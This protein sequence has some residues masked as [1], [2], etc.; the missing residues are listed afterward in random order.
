MIA[1]KFPVDDNRGRGLARSQLIGELGE[2]SLKHLEALGKRVE[3][4]AGEVLF[5]QEDAGDSIYIVETGSIEISIL[6]VSGKKLALNVMQAPDVFGEIA[7]LDGGPRTATATTLEP[8]TLLRFDRAEI[9]QEIKNRPELAANLI[10]IL[11]ARLR[12]VSQQVEDLAMLNIEGRLASRLLILHKKFS[13]KYGKLHLS[14]SELAEFLGAT[15]ESINKILQEW[16]ASGLIELSRGAVKVC[17][18]DGL[19][20]IAELG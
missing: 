12:W 18:W 13:D 20:A 19:S 8:S 6:S 3:L 4:D 16:R 15:R 17:D 10:Q 11:C 5:F 7:A 9:L 14:Q 2:E 1:A